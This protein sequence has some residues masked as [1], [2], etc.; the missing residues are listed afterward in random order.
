MSRAA[1]RP[2]GD[3]LQLSE[4][5]LLELAAEAVAHAHRIGARAVS[6]T[7][8]EHAG[9]AIR[10]RSG[11]PIASTR[12]AGHALA[13]T[14]FD[15]GRTG[16]AT[17]EAIDPEAM[18]RA[19]E[20]A[21]AI[22]AHVEGDAAA[23]LAEPDWLAHESV[24]IPLYA[25]SGKGAG[26]LTDIALEAESLALDHAR[27]SGVPV[28]ID[29]A[30]A[31][32]A[33]MRW[34]CV[35][36]NGFARAASASMQSRA[37]VAIAG[38]ADEMVRNWWHS[39]ERREQ[40]LEAAA[41]IGA[42]AVDR[43]AAGLGAR[44]LPTQSAPVLLDARVAASLVQDVVA[45]LAGQ[46]QYQKSS[47]LAGSLGSQQ[48]ADH[49]DLG[50]NP[51]EP[52]GLASASWDA[53]G[54]SGSRRPIVEAGV[55]AGYFLGVRS[56]RKLGMRSTGNAGGPLNL[57]LSSRRAEAGD[58]LAA[59]L[60]KLD[61]GLWIT[62]FSGGGVN[63]ATGSFSRAAKGFWV[64]NGRIVHPVRDVTV[65]G[66]L[67]AM[68]RGIVAVGADHHRQGAIRTGSVLIETMR[69]AGR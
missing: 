12:E 60:R 30:S 15:D 27:A 21:R 46:A 45:G 67:P 22:A 19:V 61:R 50:E 28:R 32:S 56:A 4:T 2:A 48:L 43:A 68:L 24:Q 35:Q 38:D 63:P 29:E 53:E 59:M 39:A 17:T 16:H 18:C 13:V 37:C 55:I 7:A 11:A 5:S 31:T 64:E 57:T 51:F 62:Q 36:S 66:E 40:D 20:H 25:P 69:I 1:T 3:G 58:D 26:A 52:F 41:T 8:S 47:F 54:V 65:A 34:A 6:V 44:S 49:V 33:D 23:G 42:Q 14:I 10:V 9:A